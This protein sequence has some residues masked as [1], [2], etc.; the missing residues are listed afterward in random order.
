MATDPAGTASLGVVRRGIRKRSGKPD[1]YG[2]P[3]EN[4]T[5]ATV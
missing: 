4:P 2:N 5:A 1:R 3:G